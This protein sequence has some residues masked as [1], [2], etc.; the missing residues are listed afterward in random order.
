MADSRN[1]ARPASGVQGIRLARR[2]GKA[3][4]ALVSLCILVGL[5]AY[6]ILF[7]PLAGLNDPQAAAVK[8]EYRVAQ[9]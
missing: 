3:A 4:G 7:A 1:T 9:L 6:L 8:G 5:F 2:A